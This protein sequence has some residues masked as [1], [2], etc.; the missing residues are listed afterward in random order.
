MRYVLIGLLQGIFFS[1]GM[2]SAQVPSD[3]RCQA[4]ASQFSESPDSL[5]TQELER[6]RFCVNQ[7]LEFRE[8]R[9]GGELL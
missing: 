7:A 3:T 2:V 1:V 4:L 9:L 8:Q 6:L 5:A